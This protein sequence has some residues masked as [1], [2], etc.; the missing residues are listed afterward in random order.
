MAGVVGAVDKVVEV[1][2]A[3]SRDGVDV[4][5]VVGDVMDPIEW[6]IAIPCGKS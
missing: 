5:T 1:E 6:I 2:A 3:D 4:A